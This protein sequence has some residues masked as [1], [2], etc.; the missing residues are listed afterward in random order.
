MHNRETVLGRR[1]VVWL[2]AMFALLLFAGAIAPR[3]EVDQKPYP[4]TPGAADASPGPVRNLTLRP[5]G[6][7]V[8]HVGENVA[9]TVAVG[10]SDSV[11]IDALGISQFA[12]R[13][14]PAKLMFLAYPAGTYPVTSD[15][16]GKTIGTLVVQPPAPA[17]PSGSPASGVRGVP[18]AA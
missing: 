7:V 13:R 5:G 4:A 18:A 12:D 10:S 9:L 1:L 16:T 11:D 3:R 14:T 17:P 15:N 8:V 6:R 2:L